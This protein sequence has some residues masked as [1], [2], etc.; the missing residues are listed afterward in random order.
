MNAGPAPLAPAPA[1]AGPRVVTAPTAR[2]DRGEP[3]IRTHRLTKK[4]GTLT[5]VNRLDLEVLSYKLLIKASLFH[6]A[7]AISSRR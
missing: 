3:V 1:P 4:Y 6:S 5:A 2:P 7:S